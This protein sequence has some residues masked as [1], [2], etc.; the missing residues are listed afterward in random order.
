[1]IE[2]TNNLISMNDAAVVKT[3]GT[4]IKQKRLQM[5]KSQA[6]LAK[7]AG[8]N[9]STII[10]IENGESINLSSLV[11]IL[12]VLNQLHTLVSFIVEDEISPIEYARLK[13]SQRKKA[14]K[15][16]EVKNSEDEAKW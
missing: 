13:E 9:R 16:K 8:L 10:K 1:M 14:S 7:E 6:F 3:I 15:R 12:R 5:N 4:F 11:Q 2:K